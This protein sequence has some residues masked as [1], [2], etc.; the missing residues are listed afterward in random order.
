[1]TAEVMDEQGWFHTGDIG[2]MVEGQF[3][4]I[5]D[6]KKEIFKT[7]GGKYVAP[8]LIENKLKE[9]NLIEQA[10]VVGDGQKFPSVLLV[11][12]FA[13]LREWAK[14]QGLTYTSD[15]GMIVKAEVLDKFQKELD[16]FNEHFA[17]Y[18]RVKKFTLLPVLWDVE[19][20]ELTPTLKLKRKI[21]YAKYKDW[22]D[23]MYA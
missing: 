15:A 12:S 8:Q 16:L 21:I 10:M 7:S 4:K 20:G 11:P 2:E 14:T 3:L 5:T 19:G 18:E 17:Q 1:M 13:A 6:R 23:K 9:S 22:I